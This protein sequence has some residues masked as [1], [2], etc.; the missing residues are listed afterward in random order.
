MT[1]APILK[2]SSQRTLPFKHR[3][4]RLR[5]SPQLR[6]LVRETALNPSKLVM[7]FFI[8]HHPEHEAAIPA[9]PGISQ[10]SATRALPH[11]ERCLNAGIRA[12][13]LFGIPKHK[14]ASGSDAIS[15]TGV[16]A[17]AVRTIK[18]RFPELI[19]ITD[20]CFCEYTAHGHCGIVPA[21]SQTVDNDATLP[22]L[23]KQA[24]I[25]AQAGADI[26][27][28]SAMLDGMVA[29]IRTALDA[30]QYSQIPILSYA[31]KFVSAFYGPFRTAAASQM[32]FGD[33]RSYQMDPS[34]ARE[35]LR[36]A[37][38]DVAE[39]ADLLMV[40]PAT[41]YLDIIAML[42]RELKPPLPIAA[43]HVSGEYAMLKAAAAKGWLDEHAALAELFTAFQ[44]A[45]TAFVITYAALTIAEHKLI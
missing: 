12:I 23:A 8:H 28:P 37:L 35:A 13:I 3:P 45:G 14:D 40:K 15:A 24:V 30:E 7:P 32:Q 22:L 17:E 16:I 36:E 39:G 44:R 29:S 19:V 26:I 31:V 1:S 27:A 43:Y 2:A 34:N 25:Q 33:R 41:P 38:L 21:G 11:I 9:L 42:H 20:C 10:Y 5:R 18:A 6:A 4:R